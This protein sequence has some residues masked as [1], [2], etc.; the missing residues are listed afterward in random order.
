LEDIYTKLPPSIA[1]M[2]MI[3]GD[4]IK[5]AATYDDIGDPKSSAIPGKSWL[6]ALMI[7]D[8]QFEVGL[9]GSSAI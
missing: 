6:K 5:A 9:D 4:V 1:F 7:G 3:D 2:P 8:C